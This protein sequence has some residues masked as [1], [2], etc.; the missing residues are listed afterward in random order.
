MCDSGRL[1]D[2]VI[3]VIFECIPYFNDP[4]KP[5]NMRQEHCRGERRH[6]HHS[7]KL[8]LAAI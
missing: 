3:V 5:P 8:Y 7:P 6:D 4:T 2:I 1:P